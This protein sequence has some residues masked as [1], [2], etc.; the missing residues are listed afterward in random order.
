M[1][2]KHE[3]QSSPRP[4]RV[5]Q[6]GSTTPQKSHGGIIAILLVA[7]IFLTGVSTALGLLNIRLF[8]QINTLEENSA[9]SFS[10]G[11]E[12]TASLDSSVTRFPALGI[13]G[14]R[15][16]SFY[17]VYY[18]LPQGIYVTEVTGSPTAGDRILPG[19]VLTCINTQP[20][21]TEVQLQ[22]ILKA[23]A[24]GDMV[25]IEV[26]RSQQTHHLKVRIG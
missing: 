10:K 8:K 3:V 5:Y 7:V 19:D 17:Q 14:Q 24:S 20:I 16:S 1:E 4:D 11:K 6:T 22:D 9:V 2:E 15:L 23:C 12:Q 18:H 21:S 13:A 26:Y 25:N